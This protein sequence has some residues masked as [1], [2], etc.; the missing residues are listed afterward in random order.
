MMTTAGPIKFVPWIQ[1]LQ[2]TCYK[3]YWRH[4]YARKNVSALF[5]QGKT[6]NCNGFSTLR[7]VFDAPPLDPLVDI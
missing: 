2:L 1:E 4:A 3:V 6:T 7:G 5:S